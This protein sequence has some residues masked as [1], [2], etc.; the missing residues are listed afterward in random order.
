MTEI[1]KQTVRRLLSFFGLRLEFIRTS[2]SCFSKL[3]IGLVIDVGANIGQYGLEIRREGYTGSIYSFEP[4]I[5]AYERLLQNTYDDKKWHVHSRC[6]VGDS[7]DEVEINVAG[8]SYSS[9]I[10]EMLPSHISA[11]P[12]SGTVGT[13][14]AK[15]ITL[16]SLIDMWQSQEGRILLKIDTQGFEEEVLKGADMTI[17]YVRAV[18][19]ELSVVEL[20]KGQSL[21]RYFFDLLEA[22]GFCLYRIIP[23]FM[24]DQSGR[25]LQFDAIFVRN[26]K[27]P[28]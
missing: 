1:F 2:E 17:A 6:A 24:D 16:D 8:N 19:I 5:D 11:A 9:S 18:Q 23:G 14:Y 20:Y 3:D 27:L 7:I 13:N 28:Q 12:N 26:E 15:M 4:L 25:L 22:K 10:K 21:Y